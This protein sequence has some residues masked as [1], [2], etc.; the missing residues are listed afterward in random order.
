MASSL[1]DSTSGLGV[2]MAN[3]KLN[4]AA[5][6]RRAG[7][8][9]P[10]HGKVADED[11]AVAKARQLGYPVVVKPADKE[12]GVGVAA[13]LSTEE[14][15]LS[16]FAHARQASASVLVE[17][18]V[19]GSDF[20]L[21]VF[22]G[23][24]LQVIGRRPGGVVGDGRCTLAEL[25]AQEATTP[26]SL[27]R[28]R[29]HRMPPLSLDAEALGL[30]RERGMRADTVVPEG[31]FVALRRRANVSSGG[32]P[33][34]IPVERVHPDNIAVAID[35]AAALRLNLAGVDLMVPDIGSS[36]METGG[37]ICEVNAQPQ[38]SRTGSPD[39][40]ADIL[41]A[42]LGPAHT[43]PI[44]LYMSPT[45]PPTV[46]G[47]ASAS[48]A[49]VVGYSSLDGGW[50]N[51]RRTGA[52]QPNSFRAA[53]AL[54]AD[55]RLD[56][57]VVHMT[58]QDVVAFGL[59]ASRIH[60]AAVDTQALTRSEAMA[61]LLP[62]V[63]TTLILPSSSAGTSMAANG[64]RTCLSDDPWKALSDAAFHYQDRSIAT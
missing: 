18:H 41:S 61:Y 37:I 42:L 28:Q 12:R 16:A 31:L 53:R 8:P 46:P 3:N 63:S 35:A 20:R 50:L 48:S 1:I 27:R 34:S 51:G 38:I 62:H 7:L 33:I 19:E 39:I 58:P 45:P 44:W 4:T 29:E 10:V 22:E 25:V 55:S 23:R 30:A 54:L 15:V 64:P 14:A 36:W 17:K 56:A 49:R 47:L 52:L 9:A 26:D 5:A 24:V 6:L 11:A 43:I 57:A 2:Q 60:G 21:T 59:P 13:G 32:V 40:Y